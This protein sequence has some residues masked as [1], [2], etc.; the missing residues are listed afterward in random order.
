MSSKIGCGYLKCAN[1]IGLFLA[2]LFVICFV[3]YYIGPAE[4]GLHLQLLHLT[5]FWFSGMNVVSF[6]AGLI[7]TYIWGY[8]VV[9]AWWLVGCCKI[10][11]CSK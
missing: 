9:G 1:R 2:I 5:Y 8:I 4:Q 6:I 7:Q 11:N 3:W 10:S